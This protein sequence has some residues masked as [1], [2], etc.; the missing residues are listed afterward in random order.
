MLGLKCNCMHN[1]LAVV[2]S[3]FSLK[4]N[5]IALAWKATDLLFQHVQ[6]ATME[7]AIDQRP[8]NNVKDTNLRW[9]HP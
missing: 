5:Y 2:S 4:T 3:L 1:W 7:T 9:A 6:I 8:K